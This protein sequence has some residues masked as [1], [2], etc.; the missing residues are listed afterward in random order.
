MDPTV[1]AAIIAATAT[2]VAAIIAAIVAVRAKRRGSNEPS[3]GV[4]TQPGS[5]NALNVANAGD[6]T[7]NVIGSQNTTIDRR[8]YNVHI[9]SKATR[10][11]AELALVDV[12]TV[13]T[14]DRESKVEFKVRNNSDEVVFLKKADFTLVNRWDLPN[15]GRMPYAERVSWTYD[16]D[17]ANEHTSVNLSQV[18]EP[19]KVDRFDFRIGSTIP[20][21]NLDKYNFLGLFIYLIE[22]NLIYNEDDRILKSP[23]VLLHID[24]PYKISA[25]TQMRPDRREVEPVKRK[26]QEILSSINETVVCEPWL[27]EAI[28]SWAEIDLSQLEQHPSP[29]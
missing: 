5:S 3:D 29:D 21:Y 22:I 8:L 14:D 27:L 4:A 13:Y 17:L 7:D 28:E 18:V 12:L 19:N 11:S 10:T 1:K 9:E 15:P 23:K 16:V 26:A 24:P 6:I 25:L 20:D 2:I